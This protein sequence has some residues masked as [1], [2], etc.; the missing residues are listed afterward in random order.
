MTF[1]RILITALAAATTGGL[2][3]VGVLAASANQTPA[4]AASTTVTANA[5]Q[6]QAGAPGGTENAE[7]PGETEAESASEP[8]GDPAGGLESQHDGQGQEAGEH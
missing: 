8:A 1:K 6:Q 7:S 2:L 4:S 5:G 3:G